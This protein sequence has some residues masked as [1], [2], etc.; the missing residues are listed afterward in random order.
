MLPGVRRLIKTI[1]GDGDRVAAMTCRCKE[2]CVLETCTH[3]GI[4][5][6]LGSLEARKG[7][8]ARVAP[9]SRS[10][11]C[12]KPGWRGRAGPGGVVGGGQ[13]WPGWDPRG[14]WRGRV[15]WEGWRGVQDDFLQRTDAIHG[16]FQLDCPGGI[17]CRSHGRGSAVWTDEACSAAWPDLSLSYCR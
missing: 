1:W 16:H 7:K 15:R 4:R 11:V 5:Q 10:A 8:A 3:S 17:I 9:A 13:G 12:G 2:G 6:G 14:L